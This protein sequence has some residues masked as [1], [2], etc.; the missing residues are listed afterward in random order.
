MA[1]HERHPGAAELFGDRPRLFGIAGVVADLQRQLL[2]Q[3][4]TLGVEVGDGLFGAVLHLPAEC[5]L[6]A[7]HRTGH[8]DGDV[9]RGG[10]RREGERRAEREAEKF[11]SSHEMIPR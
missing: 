4:A 8:G 2:R 5:G 6:A 3:H 7:G 10:R 1:G 11:Q 9:L